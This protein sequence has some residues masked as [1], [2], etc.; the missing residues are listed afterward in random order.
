MELARARAEIER[1]FLGFLALCPCDCEFPRPVGTDV[2]NPEPHLGVVHR[3][4]SLKE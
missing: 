1:S 3:R 2:S 4:H